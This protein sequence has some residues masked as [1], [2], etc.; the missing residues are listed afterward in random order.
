MSRSSSYKTR[1][2]QELDQRLALEVRR[3]SFEPGLRP[4]R[5]RGCTEQFGMALYEATPG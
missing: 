1:L 4:K 3:G 2:E 5:V